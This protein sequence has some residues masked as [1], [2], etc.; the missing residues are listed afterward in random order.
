[1]DFWKSKIGAFV[2]DGSFVLP[3]AVRTVFVIEILENGHVAVS[4]V[5][6]PND[7]DSFRRVSCL[8][9][10]HTLPRKPNR[11][12]LLSIDPARHQSHI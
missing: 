10:V 4:C 9:S 11:Q 3:V 6:S 2:F 7:D 5:V 8:S 12:H 1:M